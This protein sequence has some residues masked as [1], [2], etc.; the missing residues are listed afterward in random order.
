MKN[1]T[2]EKTYKDTLE[3]FRP[4]F[5][6]IISEYGSIEN[7]TFEHARII[8]TQLLGAVHTKQRVRDYEI[9]SMTPYNERPEI[10]IHFTKNFSDNIS[11]F[12]PQFYAYVPNYLRESIETTL[13]AIDKKPFTHVIFSAKKIVVNH[14]RDIVSQIDIPSPTEIKNNKGNRYTISDSYPIF[15]YIDLEFMKCVIS[16]FSV[17]HK[18]DKKRVSYTPIQKH[19][20]WST[21]Q[22]KSN[23]ST[24]QGISYDSDSDKTSKSSI[25][26]SPRKHASSRKPSRSYKKSASP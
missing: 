7:L 19:R 6:G 16:Y 5:K 8:F 4:T 9:V 23:W 14:N 18:G 13:K 12:I 22:G 25:T 24:D 2:N 10:T 1:V 26:A 11:M 20:N 15:E 3:N 21:D 17:S